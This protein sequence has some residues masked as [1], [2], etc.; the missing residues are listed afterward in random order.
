MTSLAPASPPTRIWASRRG[1]SDVPALVGLGRDHDDAHRVLA[2]GVVGGLDGLLLVA[3]RGRDHEGQ[4]AAEG[5]DAALLADLDE[6]L[7]DRARRGVGQVDDHGR[8][9]VRP[10]RARS[11]SAELGPQVPG[12]YCSGWPCV[13]QNSSIGSR[14][15]QRELDLLV[16]REQRRVAEQ[17]VEDESLVGLGARLGERVAVA[18]VHRDVAHLHAGAGHLRAEADRDALVGLHADDEGVLAELRGLAVGEQLLR[19]AL[20]HDRDL[21]DAASE[22]L[23][24]AQVE[25]HAR[26]AAGADRRASSRR[27]S[28]SSTRGSCRPRRGSR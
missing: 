7:R 3:G 21:G 2:R 18:E 16:A 12:R 20:E 28:R 13:A 19:R 23:A 15:F 5:D 27:R 11:S 9:Q 22:A 1:A 6:R 25:R 10:S 4:H 8:L 14:I 26:P 24:R 17:H